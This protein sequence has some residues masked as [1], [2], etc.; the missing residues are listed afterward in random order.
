[1]DPWGAQSGRITQ[2]NQ[3]IDRLY[4]DKSYTQFV[5]ETFANLTK[6]H[7]LLHDYYLDQLVKSKFVDCSA[8]AD[9]ELPPLTTALDYSSPEQRID[10]SVIAEEDLLASYYYLLNDS[11]AIRA[12]WNAV[13]DLPL[14]GSELVVAQDQLKSR[15]VVLSEWA[16]IGSELQNLRK[17]YSAWRD[18]VEKLK[19]KSGSATEYA[20]IQAKA[21]FAAQPSMIVQ[22]RTP[23]GREQAEVQWKQEWEQLKALAAKK[24]LSV[25]EWKS[26]GDSWDFEL[27]NLRAIE[28]AKAEFLQSSVSLNIYLTLVHGLHC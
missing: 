17:P 16:R 3:A 18:A 27:R 12:E 26:G 7:Y 20:R 24:G 4:S 21:V 2:A 19:E 25:A 22:L 10:S 11:E 6:H 28:Q 5:K 8:L 9:N 13:A 15:S 1:M 14:E 23:E